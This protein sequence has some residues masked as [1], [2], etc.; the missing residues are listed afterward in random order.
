MIAFNS[1]LLLPL[2]Q[3]MTIGRLLGFTFNSY[4]LLQSKFT[5][6]IVNSYNQLSILIYCF[7]YDDVGY[8]FHGPLDLPFNSYL[9]LPWTCCARSWP[10]KERAFN[11][12]LLFLE[13]LPHKTPSSCSTAFNS[14]LLFPKEGKEALVALGLP[15]QFLSIV[16]LAAKFLLHFSAYSAFQFLSI[17]SWI[18][19]NWY[20]DKNCYCSFNSY[21]L[22]LL[23]KTHKDSDNSLRLSILIYCFSAATTDYTAGIEAP[24][25]I[26]IYCFNCGSIYTVSLN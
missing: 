23:V 24:L 11:S 22:F 6:V 21:L 9:L 3:N 14:Y 19:I 8:T 15:F 25:S 4:L 16:S 12:Y 26:L 10:E 2:S 1:Y 18:F 20:K 17:V 7:E 13:C 5:I